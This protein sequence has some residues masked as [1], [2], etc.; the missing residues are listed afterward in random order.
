MKKKLLFCTMTAFMLAANVCAQ[1]WKMVVAHS[2]GTFDT[3]AVEKVKDVTFFKT[4][5]QP[6]TPKDLGIEFVKIPAGSFL[7]GSPNDEPQRESGE[8]QHKVTITKD[9]YMSKY[10]ITFEQYD[11]FCEATGRQKPSDYTWGRENRPVIDVSW[12]MLQLSVNG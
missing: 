7:M 6:V 9:F 5:T 10:P 12:T 2:D 3:I 1:N 8:I 4:S 11:K